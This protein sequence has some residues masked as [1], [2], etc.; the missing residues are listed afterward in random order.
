MEYTCPDEADVGE[1][2]SAHTKKTS[3]GIEKVRNDFVL[4]GE[5]AK[6]IIEYMHR[7]AIDEYGLSHEDAAEIY[8]TAQQQG[9]F[10]GHYPNIRQSA[11]ENKINRALGSYSDDATV[12]EVVDQHQLAADNV[13]SRILDDWKDALSS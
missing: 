1:F 9:G 8:D 13:A 5:T 4:N 12:D 3:E 2:V 11:L 7:T 10:M 6:D